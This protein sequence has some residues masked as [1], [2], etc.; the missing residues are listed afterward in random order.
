M[1]RSTGPILLVDDCEDD[2]L[3][4]QRAFRRSAE[5]P[6]VQWLANGNDATLYLC[7]H[8]EFQDRS[9]FPLPTLILLDLKMPVKNGFEVLRWLRSYPAFAS[10]PVIVLSDCIDPRIIRRAYELGAN[11][12][13]RKP[14]SEELRQQL[15]E[16]LEQYWIG[17]NLTVASEPLAEAGI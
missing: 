7:G 16:L 6:R 15:A 4:L 2:A 14:H 11:S 5:F 17:M 10:I 13:I 9:L 12:F 3:L 8:G 1:V